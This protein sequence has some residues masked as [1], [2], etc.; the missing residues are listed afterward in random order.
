LEAY[1]GRPTRIEL[2]VKKLNWM[3]LLDICHFCIEEPKI[4][5]HSKISMLLCDATSTSLPYL[6]V[7]PLSIGL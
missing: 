6:T 5:A 1:I 2:Q 7:L 4:K 3:S